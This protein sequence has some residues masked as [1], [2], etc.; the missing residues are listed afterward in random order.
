MATFVMQALGCEVAAINTVHFS[1][2]KLVSFFCDL[3]CYALR[4]EGVDPCDSL[5]SGCTQ[6]V[7]VGLR[8]ACD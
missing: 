2:F 7:D 1:E 8:V 3:V 6:M 4:F 5:V